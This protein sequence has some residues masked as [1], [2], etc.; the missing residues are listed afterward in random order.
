MPSSVAGGKIVE[1]VGLRIVISLRDRFR[2]GVKRW[3]AGTVL[4]DMIQAW[5]YWRWC[6][7]GRSVPPTHVVKQMAIKS[8]A[9]RFGTKAFVETGTYLGEMTFAVRNLFDEIHTIEL[10]AEL[11]RRAER[12]FARYDHIHVVEG[13]SAKRLPEVLAK[14]DQ[15]CLFWLDGHHCGALSA[16]AESDTPIWDELRDVL[17]HP[18]KEHVVLIDDARLFTGENDYPTLRDLKEAVLRDRPDLEC[19]VADDIIRIHKPFDAFG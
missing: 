3:T 10:S 6:Q 12:R 18:V 11:C 17:G 5:L 14:I 9:R 13:D 8:Y 15:P 7:E 19:E 1:G 16:Q 2:L 4:Y